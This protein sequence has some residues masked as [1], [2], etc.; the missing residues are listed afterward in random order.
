MMAS[1]QFFKTQSTISCDLS[2]KHSASPFTTSLCASSKIVDESAQTITKLRKDIN[3][4][5]K[6]KAIL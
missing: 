2:D 5:S 4:L 6:D 1:H 3:E